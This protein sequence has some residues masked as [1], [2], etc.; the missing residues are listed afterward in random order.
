MWKVAILT[1]SVETLSY[2]AFLLYFSGGNAGPGAVIASTL[3]LSPFILLIGLPLWLMLASGI[4]VGLALVEARAKDEIWLSIIVSA[5]AG[6]VVG[7]L[8]SLL[9]HDIGTW[10]GFTVSLMFAAF[11]SCAAWVYLRRKG[12]AANPTI[13]RDAPQAGRPSS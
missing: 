1:A 2:V 5:L 6:F 10:K 9:L 4:Y 11:H 8:L 12:L 3:L 7:V 13:E